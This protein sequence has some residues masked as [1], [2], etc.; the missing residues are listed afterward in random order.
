MKV[1]VVE[2]RA[3]SP[4]SQSEL[5][6]LAGLVKSRVR[7]KGR[8][9]SLLVTDNQGISRLNWEFFKRKGPT[10]VISFSYL[11]D[12]N[13]RGYVGD[14][15]ISVEKAEEEAKEAGMETWER[16]ARLFVHGLLHIYGYDHEAEKDREVMEAMEEEIMEVFRIEREGRG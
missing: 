3:K 4:L 8:R 6:R 2:E 1:E 12:Y 10:N 5:S 11:G 14:I 13:P 7:G 15:V 16:F 9:I